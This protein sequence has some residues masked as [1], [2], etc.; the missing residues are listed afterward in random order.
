MN[1]TKSSVSFLSKIIKVLLVIILAL[2]FN[3]FSQS[4]IYV[5]H[6]AGGS[7]NGTSWTDAYTSLQSALDDAASGDSIWV[8]AGTYK[9]SKD[10]TGNNSPADNRT[11]TFQLVDSVSLF[12][13]FAG[14]ETNFEERDWKT[15][16]TILSGDIGTIDDISDNCYN[17]VRGIDHSSIDGF[18]ITLGNANG[19]TANETNMGGGILNKN[20][21]NV[22]ILN[23]IFKN[24]K[25]IQG[26]GVANFYCSDTLLFSNCIF[27]SDSAGC[28]GAIGNWDN[29]AI[30]EKCV[31]E[32]N[33]ADI[34]NHTP[35][36][37]MGS[38]IYN[39]GSGSTSEVINSTFLNNES[40]ISNS[41]AIHDRGVHS[42]VKNSIFLDNP[43]NDF[44][45]VGTVSY[46]LTNQSGYEGNN[47]NIA[48]DPL[49]YETGE[50]EYELNWASPCI[51]A[52]DPD[53]AYNDPD[54]SRND[55]GASHIIS[56][57]QVDALISV[58]DTP[59]Q[60]FVYGNYDVFVTMVNLGTDP[61]TSAAIDWEVD[62]TPQTTFNWTGNLAGADTTNSFTIG[63]YS[64]DQGDHNIKVWTS[65][66]SDEFHGNDTLDK[67]VYASAHMDAGIVSLD[68]P[69]TL[70]SFEPSTDLYVSFKNYDTDST[71]T[72][73]DIGW[74]VDGAAQT[75]Y[76]WSDSLAPGDTRD[77]ILFESF[78]FSRGKHNFKIWTENPNGHSDD[79]CDN[80]TLEIT[81]YSRAYDIGVSTL[82]TPTNPDTTGNQQEVNVAIKNFSQDS[83]I[84]SARIDWD[85][86][87][88]PQVHY[89]WTGSLSP[90]EISDSIMIGKYDLPAKD[91]LDFKIWTEAPNGD[92]D[93][94]HGNDTL[95]KE[96]IV[97]NPLC[98]TFTIGATGDFLTF[99]KAIDSLVNGGGVCGPVVFMV[100]TGTYNEQITIPEI[101]GTSENYTITFQSATGDST[102]VT[103][104]NTG[105]GYTVTLDGAD[106][107]IF[108]NMTISTDAS[109]TVI[110]F[111]NE[112]NYNSIMNCRILGEA[113]SSSLIYVNYQNINNIFFGNRIVN[114]TKG[115]H[116]YNGNSTITGTEIKENV[117]ENQS[118]EAIH[119]W[120]VKG[121][122][123]IGNTI[124]SN[125][126]I[127]GIYFYRCE[128]NF[129]IE[130]NKILLS[131][132]G[133]G[134]YFYYGTNNTGIPDN[135]ANNF[136]YVNASD[137]SHYGI[138]VES[139]SR[140]INFF[141]NNINIT[142]NA[143]GS[144]NVNILPI[145]Y[146]TVKIKNN[147]LVNKAG[148]RAISY[149]SNNSNFASDY[150]CFYSNGTYLIN[151]EKTLEEHQSSSGQDMHS[152]S[153]DPQFVSDSD[154]HTFSPY[155]NNQGTLIAEITTDIDGESRNGTNPDIGADEYDPKPPLSGTYSIGPSDLFKTFNDAVDSLISV[156]V[157]GPV[158]F[159]AEDGTYN[160]QVTIPWIANSSETNTITFKSVS[161]DSTKVILTYAAT[162]E[163]D[164]YT[165]KLDK[166]EYITF[167]DITLEA[168]GAEYAR[169]VEI[170]YRTHNNTFSNNRLLGVLNK[171]ELVYSY[172]SGDT[173]NVFNNNLFSNGIRG[174]NMTSGYIT[175]GPAISGN[176]FIDQTGEA[177]YLSSYKNPI[178]LSNYIYSN[179]TSTS[180]FL[181]NNR[182]RVEIGK[183]NILLPNGGKGIELKSGQ[184][185]TTSDT[186]LIYNN[187]I[188]LNA[189]N[190]G[191]PEYGICLN[192]NYLGAKIIFNTIH[193]TGDNSSS[194]C[195][196]HIYSTYIDFRN[197]NLV[198]KAYGLAIGNSYNLSISNFNNLFSNGTKLTT[199][200]ADLEHWQTTYNKDINSVS[201]DPYFVVDT[202][203]HILN[204]VLK[205][206]GIPF[207]EVTQDLD[208]DIRDALN[209][210]IGADEFTVCDSPISGTFTIG[211]T[212]PD[213]E[214]MNDAVEKL[215]C[216]GVNGPV[217]F[218]IATDTL[219]EQISIQ[220]I[221][222]A[223]GTNT[224]TFQ[225]ETG[226]SSDVLITF[227]PVN[228][229]LNYTIRLDGADFITFKNLSISSGENWGSAVRLYNEATNN[230][231]VNNKFFYEGTMTSSDE[232]AFIYTSGSLDSNNVF[233]SNLFEN[234]SIGIYMDGSAASDS[235][236]G[237]QIKNNIFAEMVRRGVYLQKHKNLNISGNQFEILNSTYSFGLCITN[238]TGLIYNNFI[239]LETTH[240][241]NGIYLYNCSSI[242]VLHNTIMITGN[243]P[244]YSRS[245]YY[246]TPTNREI[247][248]N[249]FVNLA[250]GRVIACDTA[251]FASDYN[252]LYTNGTRLVENWANLSDWQVA[253]G[254]DQHSVS[255]K[256]QFLADT[257][258]H[259]TDPWMNNWGTPIAEVTTDI[260]GEAR[261]AVTPDVGA[262]E[263]DGI[264]PFEGEYT[265]GATGDFESFTEAVD[266]ITPVGISGPVTFK[267]ESGTYNEQ[268]VITAIPEVTET[269]TITF[270]SASGDSMDVILQFDATASENYTVKMDSCSFITF[271]N[272]TIKAL[273]ITYARVIEFAGGASNNT[274]S[275]NVLEGLGTTNAVVYSIGDQDNSNLFEYN[276]IIGGK[277]GIQM[278]GE[279]ASLLESGTEITGNVF[280][281]QF[282]GS[283]LLKFNNAPLVLNNQMIH[284]ELIKDIWAGIY[285]DECSGTGSNL[286]LIAN[287]VIAFNTETMSAGIILEGS[288]YQKVYHNSVNV[289]GSTENSRAF[290]Q[291]EGGSNNILTNNIFNNLSGGLVIYTKDINSFTSDYNNFYSSGD[292]FIYYGVTITEFY[293]INDL[294]T[295]QTDY[296]KDLNSYSVD[297]KFVSDTNLLPSSI[298]LDGSGEA[299]AEVTEDFAG[300]QRDP[301]NP[302]IGAYEF[303]GCTNSGTFSIGPSGADYLT[304]GEAVESLQT[305]W[306]DGPIIFNVQSGTYNEQLIFTEVPGASE[307]N[308]ITFQSVSGDST[309]VILTWASTSADTNYTV[310][311]DG[312]DYIS[313][314]NLTLQATGN[315]YA[316]V[317]GILNGASNNQFH[318]NRFIGVNTT[319]P[320]NTNG[321]LVFSP[322]GSANDTNTVFNENLFL[323]GSYGIYLSGSYSYLEK[324]NQITG[325]RFEDQVSYG[326]YLYY[327][328]SALISMNEI[329]NTLSDKD[330]YGIYLHGINS[331]INKN[332]INL[333]NIH[334][335][336]IGIDINGPY[337][338]TKPNFLNNNFIHIST[339]SSQGVIGIELSS[340]C[341]SYYNSINITG[342]DTGS[343]AILLPTASQS[344][345]LK[346][347]ISVNNAG[348][349]SIGYSDDSSDNVSSDYNDLYSNGD[350]L[351]KYNSTNLVDLAE[352][353]TATTFDSNSVSVDPVFLSNS[354][355]HT[356]NPVI[357]GAGTP[358]TEV[359][360]DIDGEPRDVTKPDIGA[361]EFTQSIYVLE[362]EIINAC[363][364]DTVTLDAGNGYDSYSWSNSAAT[365]F[366]DVDTTGIGLD[367]VKL[368]STV[369]LGGQEYKDSLWVSFH[370]PVA[371]TFDVDTCEYN[372]VHLKA[373]GG[374]SYHWEPY[375]N[376][377][378]TCCPTVPLNNT[379]LNNIVTVYD[380][381]GCYDT[382]TAIVTP[383]SK[384][385]QPVIQFS[386][387]S[388]VSSVTGTTYDWF[389]NSNITEDTIQAILPQ[390]SGNYQVIVYNGGC[391]SDSSDS[392]NYVVGI[393]DLEGNPE[394]TLYPNPTDGKL[395][396]SFEKPFKD[397]R[398][399]VIN[400][401]GQV[402]LSRLLKDVPKG[403]T[404]EINLGDVPSGI[405]FVKFTNKIIS[406]TARIIVR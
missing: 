228:T 103:L 229:K 277:I 82:Y 74:T 295:W 350:Y 42:T 208:G 71:L 191:N 18:T 147:I 327:Q 200:S 68:D 379:I 155:L 372:Y 193:I 388:L 400:I 315:D 180:I 252:L 237:I 303:Y 291:Q 231:F 226:D 367:S 183:N 88:T 391:P 58:I 380:E 305:C 339:N 253:S 363:A 334:Y 8:A 106:Y 359:T 149:Y 405:Y 254:R 326:M 268:F 395:F 195:L 65:I 135:I 144:C 362:N 115:I 225:S 240:T 313:F 219:T 112:A 34:G 343:Y 371:V 134:I 24:N 223:S 94:Y 43:P 262:D 177:I 213:Y 272:M 81:I 281:N 111:K 279:S 353:I 15:N 365:R 156:G 246:N 348:G 73:V 50:G 265:I 260:D 396:M 338:Y 178:I 356:N 3:G 140:D 124:T 354:D 347:N 289:Y 72:N 280:E 102:D 209:P 157:G 37:G 38:A 378:D 179:Y 79:N 171:S 221:P 364:Y 52:G 60:S 119:L 346:N 48:G 7:D 306:A 101:P 328:D 28:G 11:K 345:V 383:Y 47:G 45:S 167:R 304:F 406:R 110:E 288:S 389:L 116:F 392:Y 130:K 66:A 205:G 114:G 133:T 117:F 61:L 29:K 201:V 76:N 5:K 296:S 218:N 77:S 56:S 361:D 32:D 323:S 46:T 70:C 86:D 337:P 216:C 197:N 329:S 381:Y 250:Y 17:V 352:W 10:K 369:T 247:K 284:N 374:V 188:Y 298:T 261:D 368:V 89:D 286:G 105:G 264:M 173:C 168:T 310:K 373:S 273:D 63:N 14:T 127:S 385:L 290:N 6:D 198:N 184:W 20:V 344:C 137:D 154:L 236:A 386:A 97:A 9:P 51:D 269:N 245:L 153:V 141:N 366:A 287:N 109:G 93:D 232:N 194:A 146:S 333:N 278:F 402:V 120:E 123:I 16:E 403:F 227:T 131:G 342:D 387:D 176:E 341:N 164:N 87:G 322:Y 321:A 132:G 139:N 62:G 98:D 222:G 258:L 283:I 271:Q 186:S 129:T 255:R 293:W 44:Y 300:N 331:Q 249:I 84:T 382:D 318:N 143:T 355:L 324:N 2:P 196:Y 210:D 307:T 113:G 204:P 206:A 121:A 100:E 151:N 150:N 152:F 202:S 244:S 242:P 317:I 274:L 182:D 233:D 104:S 212:T 136:I 23:C 181:D 203:Q 92:T 335:R 190:T 166:A 90:G 370:K 96:I 145:Q 165:L 234:G 26:A 294:A 174:I 169:I 33:K 360:D 67:E 241:G 69:D 64:F 170:G 39:W 107:I 95:L 80:D 185:I 83:V 211:G 301:V 319:D 235:I 308:T 22:K 399:S 404:T 172:N 54:A 282:S 257:N 325:N 314:K 36:W 384:P 239:Q 122:N 263:F 297:P 340:C 276:L 217:T 148:G 256:P 19:P 161:E 397:L 376:N 91:T 175:Y 187:F 99:Q 142:G 349:Y 108:K 393:Q 25:G 336:C 30:I 224:I 357:N 85:V 118:A 330:Y 138:Y 375:A 12:G 320:S 199:Y 220:E 248:N 207:V 160:E 125:S 398:L 309:D 266:T 189:T 390:E 59:L 53:P 126:S 192:M 75:T 238:S 1:I 358:I 285:L 49:L 292:R 215:V 27:L 128:D 40:T 158:I 41:G 55:M 377:P 251:N 275:N 302:D 311:L 270:Q 332:K 243:S 394:I 316:N 163:N 214:T 78:S 299:L 162:G 13:G 351:G 4:V 267:V 401:E 159:E 31:F 259:T 21:S 312:A 35:D 230:Q 57:P